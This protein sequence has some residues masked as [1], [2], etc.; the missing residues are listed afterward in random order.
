[1]NSLQAS[2]LIIIRIDA[3]TKEQP[4][5]SAVYNLVIPKL[6]GVNENRRGTQP[7]RNYFGGVGHEKQRACELR[8]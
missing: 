3:K 4:G 2:Q 6:R 8:L 1:M 5:V 7:L